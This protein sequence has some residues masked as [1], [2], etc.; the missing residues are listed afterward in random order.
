MYTNKLELKDQIFDYIRM[1]EG[2]SFAE[3]QAEFGSGEYGYLLKKNLYAWYSLPKEV[4]EVISDLIVT[5]RKVISF[6]CS[7]MVYMLDGVE[8]A[9]PLA[10]RYKDYNEPHWFPVVLCSV[11]EAKN[12]SLIPKKDVQKYRDAG[13]NL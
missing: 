8:P 12:K 4:V 13:Y 7:E 3:I 6:R 2:V 10:K 9:L 1:Y 11:Q 5:N